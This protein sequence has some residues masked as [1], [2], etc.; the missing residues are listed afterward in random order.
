MFR[1]LFGQQTTARTAVKQMDA[2]EL[3]A[4]MDQGEALV[5][6]DVRTPGEYEYDGHIGGAR[7]LPL[8][9][10]MSRTQE[11]PKEEPIVCVC[12]SGNRSHTACE[13][14]ARHG[15]TNVINLKGGMIGWQRA[16]L[17]T[18]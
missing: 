16:G 5:L 15:F 2:A 4:R 11:L 14:L 10:L 8:S 18:R 3:K 9:V 7:L 1:Q 13:L 12:R 6:V 17:P